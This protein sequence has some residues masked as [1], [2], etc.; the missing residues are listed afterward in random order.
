MKPLND[1][2]SA[3]RL[4]KI[5]WINFR[6]SRG[7][8]ASVETVSLDA[9]GWHVAFTCEI[10][11]EAPAQSP[12][13][14]GID[15]GV[16]GTLVL[17]TGREADAA[18][19]PERIETQRCE[20]QRVLARRKRGTYR[21]RRAL[22]RRRAPRRGRPAS[23]AT[24]TTAPHR[25]TAIGNLNTRGMSSSAKGTDADPGRNV[26]PKADL[27]RGILNAGWHLLAAILTYEMEERGKVITV[28]ARLTSQTCV[29]CGVVDARSHEGPARFTCINCGHTTHADDNAAINVARRW[30]MP[31]PDLDGVHQLSVE[32]ST[33][34]SLTISENPRS[35][36][37]RRC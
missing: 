27:N 5:G 13:V 9:L 25:V 6:H 12:A 31:L 8:R 21:R 20:A 3:L 24:S 32:A 17:P 2:W 15:R 36:G 35:S 26:R 19:E 1:S 22:A 4:P 18:R 28:P 30:N 11:H 37:R 29:A 7:V 16:A 33:R 23:E 10:E 14:V 34:R